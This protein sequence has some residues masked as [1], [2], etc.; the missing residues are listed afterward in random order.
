MPA[1]QFTWLVSLLSSNAGKQFFYAPDFGNGHIYAFIGPGFIVCHNSNLKSIAHQL[2]LTFVFCQV[3]IGI[4]G[5]H[6]LMILQRPGLFPAVKPSQVLIMFPAA[7][8]NKGEKFSVGIVFIGKRLVLFNSCCRHLFFSFG[9]ISIHHYEWA[10]GH[11][12]NSS[13]PKISRCMRMQG[14]HQSEPEKL[15]KISWCFFLF[16][17]ILAVSKSGCHIV[18]DITSRHEAV[19]SVFLSMKKVSWI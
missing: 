15:S 10:V 13:F 11:L 9:E 4:T 19:I 6:V 1:N 3:A 7:S 17:R 8:S 18:K 2:L 16:A 5:I 14:P 12:I